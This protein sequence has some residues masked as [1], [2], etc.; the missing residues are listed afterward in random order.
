MKTPYTNPLT[1]RN[2]RPV[3]GKMLVALL[4][5]VIFVTGNSCGFMHNLFAKK[6]GCP[7]DGKNVGAERILSGEKV[8]R[9][10]RFKA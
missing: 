10:P 5:M 3:T 6:S 9:A 4:L 2:S 8:P 1:P 7:S